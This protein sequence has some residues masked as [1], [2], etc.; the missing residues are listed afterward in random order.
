MLYDVNK[1]QRSKVT[2][3][4]SIPKYER[5]I[6]HQKPFL[7]HNTNN[8][9]TLVVTLQNSNSKGLP[10]T[11]TDSL[12]YTHLYILVTNNYNCQMQESWSSGNKGK[13]NESNK[14]YCQSYLK[15][16]SIKISSIL[17]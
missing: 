6:Y 3:T 7:A 13:G 5:S 8:N 16:E 1:H 9:A 10:L 15:N 17:V 4:N 11:Y 12:T 14:G 2:C